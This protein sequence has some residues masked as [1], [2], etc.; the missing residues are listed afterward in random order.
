MSIAGFS[1]L[2]IELFVST[3]E[4][5]VLQGTCP[6]LENGKFFNV[7]YAVAWIGNE[8]EHPEYNKNTDF[9]KLMFLGID[10]SR[11]LYSNKRFLNTVNSTAYALNR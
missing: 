7:A 5:L 1:T 2:F 8:L 9:Q 3:S 6:A 11:G 10:L 4:K